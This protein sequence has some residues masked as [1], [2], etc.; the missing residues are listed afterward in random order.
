MTRAIQTQTAI[1][2]QSR[3]EFLKMAS[4]LINYKFEGDQLKLSSFL[5]D[6][7]LVEASTEEQLMPLCIRL[8]KDVFLAEH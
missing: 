3:T 2:A 4:G 1:M 5:A 6:I 7:D 8:L